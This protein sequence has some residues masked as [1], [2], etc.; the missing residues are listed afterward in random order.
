MSRATIRTFVF[1]YVEGAD[2]CGGRVQRLLVPPFR[3]AVSHHSDSDW[4]SSPLVF[5]YLYPPELST[6]HPTLIQLHPIS[7]LE[8]SL[9]DAK[10]SGVCISVNVNI[11]S[12]KSIRRA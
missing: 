6:H 5:T 1:S 4:I 2:H 12:K 9:S 11:N 7:T 8:H 3:F 10:P